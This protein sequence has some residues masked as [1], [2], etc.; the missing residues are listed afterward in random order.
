[1]INGGLNTR[2]GLVD[3]PISGLCKP[4]STV[5]T[6]PLFPRNPGD[7][8]YVWY[9][10]STINYNVNTV[11]T[12]ADFF[13]IGWFNNRDAGPATITIT[14]ALWAQLNGK[15]LVVRTSYVYKR[16]LGFEPLGYSSLVCRP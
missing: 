2:T 3:A 10:A 5:S 9:G 14:D 6:L 12:D 4:G 8:F 15:Y 1:L 16:F 11:V 7:D 13:S